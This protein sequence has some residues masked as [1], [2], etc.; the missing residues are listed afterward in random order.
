MSGIA[1]TIQAGELEAIRA[2]VEALHGAAA[3]DKIR[4]EM[5]FGIMQVIRN[6]FDQ[7]AQDSQHHQTGASLGAERTGFYEKAREGTHEP[8]LEAGGVSV[9]IDAQGIAQRLF[10]GTIQARPGGFLTIPAIAIA[11]GK[12]AREFDLRLVVFGDTGLAALVSKTGAGDEGDVYYWLVRSVTQAA[13]PTVLPTEAEM[14]DAAK[15]NALAFIEQVWG[16][17][18]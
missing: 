3:S 8:Q 14:T 16:K 6:H 1:L 13:D 17:A 10:G 5:G 7:L 9:S 15:T 11:Y 2:S 18:A 12:R 4:L